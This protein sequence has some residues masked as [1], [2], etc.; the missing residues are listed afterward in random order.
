MRNLTS[1][2]IDKT[3]KSAPGLDGSP[4]A[5][6]L[7]YEAGERT[8]EMI[9]LGLKQLEHSASK[10][11]ILISPLRD[12]KNHKI[13]D[14]GCKILMQDNIRIPRGELTID[15]INAKLL[16]KKISA[17]QSKKEN[18]FLVDL[19]PILL[20]LAQVRPNSKIVAIMIGSSEIELARELGKVITTELSSQNPVLI[21]LSKLDDA[22][23]AQAEHC[24]SSRFFNFAIHQSFLH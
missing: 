22:S 6:L 23:L 1:E 16:R 24:D 9:A 5:L 3:L 18:E 11:F 8:H 4:L 14:K 10:L 20:F 19:Y 7:P 12:K 13:L 2:L 17:E 21:A 15:Q